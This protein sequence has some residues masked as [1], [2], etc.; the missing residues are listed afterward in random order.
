MPTVSAFH[1]LLKVGVVSAFVLIV[2]TLRLMTPKEMVEL[3]Q[4]ISPVIEKKG[5]AS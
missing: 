3:F 1:F 2:V 5:A 4:T